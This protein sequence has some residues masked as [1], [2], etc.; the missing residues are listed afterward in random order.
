MRIFQT[1]TRASGSRT[2]I[3]SR[4]DC[5]GLDADRATAEPT[6]AT[7]RTGTPSTARF[8][9]DLQRELNLTRSATPTKKS[10]PAKI[11]E[12]VERITAVI[13]G[14][15]S[16]DVEAAAR[17]ASGD[18]PHP[19]GTRHPRATAW[20]RSARTRRS[21][22]K[23]NTA[24]RGRARSADRRVIG[25]SRLTTARPLFLTGVRQ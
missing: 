8:H 13:R 18:H 9:N 22:R 16:G 14:L 21:T 25:C 19:A 2:G 4:D 1:Q 5:R 17:R 15:M 11:V 3:G 10:P 12:R 23:C 20:P 7:Q 24:T 6:A